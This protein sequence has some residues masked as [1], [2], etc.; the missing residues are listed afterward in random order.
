MKQRWG[1]AFV[2]RP[3][4]SCRGFGLAAVVLMSCWCADLRSAGGADSLRADSLRA[5][6]SAAP[7]HSRAQPAAPELDRAKLFDTVVETVEQRFVDKD[8]LKQMN[9]RARAD[10]VRPT[11]LAAATTDD[12]VRQIN[13]LLAELKWS[14][15]GLFTPDDYFYTMVLD[16]VG[17]SAGEP[18]LMTRRFWGAGPYYPGT[19]AFTRIID[20]RHFIDAVLEGSPA[21]RA[22]L[23]YGDEVL[24][25]DGMPYSPVAAFRGKVGTTV[26]LTVR[27]H[28]GAEPQQVPVE[29]VPLHPVKAFGEATVTS[30]RVIERGGKR[31]GYIHIWASA[32]SGSFKT[33]LKKLELRSGSHERSGRTGIRVLIQQGSPLSNPADPMPAPHAASE[34]SNPID[35]LIVD[36]RGK[37]GGNVAVV[38]QLLETLDARTYWGGYAWTDRSSDPSRISAPS[39]PYRGRTALL[40]NGDTRSAAEVMAYGFKRN[41]FGPVLGTNTAGAV[42]SGATVVMP[43][44]L[45]LYVAVYSRE[46]DGRRLEG[47]G[48]APDHHVERP[49][50]YAAGADPVLEA[51]L[52]L[53]AAQPP[54][55]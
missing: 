36:M 44:D 51:A 49:L 48:V 23:R 25:V 55:E 10:A 17:V 53:L 7:L 41:G 15:T 42:S 43:G 28:A 5:E 13:A 50:P 9:W 45:L 18:G 39:A 32:E 35:F 22:G 8:R 30:A 54:K 4:Y 20:G 6:S 2:I 26:E 12:A 31:I 3:P 29:V 14:H 46:I 38:T 1:F 21:D 11:V 34:M 24:A 33:A 27:R 52:D 47:V 37:V 19:G 40:I 16:V